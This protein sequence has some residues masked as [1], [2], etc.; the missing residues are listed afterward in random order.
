MFLVKLLTANAGVGGG[1]VP[2]F[3]AGWRQ[4]AYRV[5]ALVESSEQQPLRWSLCDALTTEVSDRD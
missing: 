1:F 3:F 5:Y 2:P 4:L